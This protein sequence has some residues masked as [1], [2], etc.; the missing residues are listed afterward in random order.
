MCK[1]LGAKQNVQ[2]VEG[3]EGDSRAGD[4][5]ESKGNTPEGS[6][7]NMGQRELLEDLRLEQ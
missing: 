3:K 6:E 5:L 4:R 1:G 2:P 7:P